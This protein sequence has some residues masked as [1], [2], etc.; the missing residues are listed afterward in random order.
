MKKRE[1]LYAIGIIVF[2]V[3]I[4]FLLM[5]SWKINIKAIQNANV[6]GFNIFQSKISGNTGNGD[7]EITLTPKKISSKIL[8]VE[9]NANTHSVELGDFD[10]YKLITLEYDG[11][12][13]NPVSAPKLSTHHGSGLLIFESE[14]VAKKFTITVQGIPLQEE[15]VFSWG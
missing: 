14:Q 9:I 6:E 11:K 1:D 4:G 3:L 5:L 7:V 10:L 2:I 8:E 13:I 12:K 15:R